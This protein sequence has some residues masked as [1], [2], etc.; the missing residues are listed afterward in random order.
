MK[1]QHQLLSCSLVEPRAN[2][3]LNNTAGLTLELNGVN[4]PES[5][6]V[7]R[8]RS[9]WGAADRLVLVDHIIISPPLLL[10]VRKP[11]IPEP[12]P[13]PCLWLQSLLCALQGWQ[14]SFSA[15]VGLKGGKWPSKKG[16]YK[17]YNTHLRL[18]LINTEL[19][20]YSVTMMNFSIQKCDID[21]DRVSAA[22]VWRRRGSE[23]RTRQRPARRA[24]HR[25]TSTR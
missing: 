11:D 17:V 23:C 21:E 18:D 1:S 24:V 2:T 12:F 6:L 14:L 4:P 20:Q 5:S 19:A 10:S 13:S 7:Y 9:E 22:V 3:A 15:S 16:V 25:N 8:T